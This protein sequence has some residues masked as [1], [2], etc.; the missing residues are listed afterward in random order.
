[1]IEIE[2]KRQDGQPIDAWLQ[3]EINRHA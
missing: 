1:M 2:L 3:T